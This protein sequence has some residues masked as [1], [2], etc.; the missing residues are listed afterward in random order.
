MPTIAQ[1]IDPVLNGFTTTTGWL[2]FSLGVL[3]KH[4]VLKAYGVLQALR[5]MRAESETDR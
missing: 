2:M 3:G 4:I 5:K 1:I